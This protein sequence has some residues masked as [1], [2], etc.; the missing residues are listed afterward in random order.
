MMSL[1]IK[2]GSSRTRITFWKCFSVFQRGQRIL[3]TVY[4]EHVVIII[5]GESLIL[6]H[7]DGKT[8]N[9]RKCHLTNEEMISVED[10]TKSHND[11]F[12]FQPIFSQMILNE[13]SIYQKIEFQKPT[14]KP[15]PDRSVRT[16]RCFSMKSRR[17]IIVLVNSGQ[18]R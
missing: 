13:K 10:F 7:A 6:W 8:S 3:S 12:E 9:F 4:L 11:F 2:R 5:D 1:L 18:Q 15:V 14:S 16:P 17:A